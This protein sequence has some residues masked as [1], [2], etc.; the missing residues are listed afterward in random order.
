VAISLDELVPKL[1]CSFANILLIFIWSFSVLCIIFQK[2]SKKRKCIVNNATSALGTNNCSV[3]LHKGIYSRLKNTVT[4][5]INS[6]N[7]FC[8]IHGDFTWKL[9]IKSFT[10]IS[11]DELNSVRV[12]FSWLSKS[13]QLKHLWTIW[14]SWLWLSCSEHELGIT[15]QST[16][17][18]GTSVQITLWIIIRNS[19]Y[20]NSYS[21][22]TSLV[23]LVFQLE[24]KTRS[25]IDNIFIDYSRHR[26]LYIKSVLNGISDHDA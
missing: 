2:L 16:M 18:V 15:I 23:Q 8:Y 4:W 25:T 22:A 24:L 20:I 3:W 13:T 9:Q 17:W 12:S 26:K 21:L 10:F 19:N 5:Y 1:N 7:L 11:C 6:L 14:T